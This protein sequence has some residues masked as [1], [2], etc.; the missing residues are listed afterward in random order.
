MTRSRVVA[1]AAIVVALASGALSSCGSDPQV[2]S[3]PIASPPQSQTSDALPPDADLEAYFAAVASYDPGLLER[4]QAS[5]ADGS[6]ASTYAGYLLELSMAAIDGGNPVP[7]AEIQPVD[8]GGYSACNGNGEANDCA[9]W[10]DFVGR[11]GKLVDFTVNGEQLDQRLFS[12]DG[13]KVSAGSLGDAEVQYAY[14]SAQSEDLLV[15]VRV[16]ASEDVTILSGGATYQLAP[17]ARV[18][19]SRY[20]GPTGTAADGT[21]TV[22]VVF[23]LCRVGGVVTLGLV[24]SDQHSES[25]ELTTG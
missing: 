5:T 16:R 10:S 4:A 20:V 15:V 11:D 23:P 18:P 14:Q 6:V 12:G 1:T 9:L 17:G 3:G 21:A 7:G 25:V 24:G 13:T 2:R 22:V 8:G 19:S